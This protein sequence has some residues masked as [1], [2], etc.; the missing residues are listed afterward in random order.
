MTDIA[1]FPYFEVQFT[2][3][4]AVFD[5][6]EVAAALDYVAQGTV[7]DLFVISHGWNNDLNDARGLYRAFFSRVREV[8]D[9]GHST[10]LGTRQFG[11][12]A[13][14]WPSRKFADA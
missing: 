7:T 14:L 13:V 1:G 10:G 9:S 2:K 5:Q 8:L 12:L 6:H 3:D 11:V 4:G